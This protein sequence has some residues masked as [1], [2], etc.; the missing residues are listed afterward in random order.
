MSVVFLISFDWQLLKVFDCPALLLGNHVMTNTKNEY[1][2]FDPACQVPKSHAAERGNGG[3]DNDE[4]DAM[5]VT[6]CLFVA[7]SHI[8][9]R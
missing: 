3:L 6:E 2:A 9:I 1:S 4:T 7:F 5:S 8:L